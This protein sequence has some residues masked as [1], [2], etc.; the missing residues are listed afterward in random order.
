[1]RRL[2][3]PI[4]R[5]I[6]VSIWLLLAASADVVIFPVSAGTV[7]SIRSLD[8]PD[9]KDVTAV[10][11]RISML[12]Q[13][14]DPRR[15][16]LPPDVDQAY[17]RFEKRIAERRDIDRILDVLTAEKDYWQVHWH[18]APNYSNLIEIFDSIRG[19]TYFRFDPGDC[20]DGGDFLVLPQ[21][22]ATEML[23]KGFAPKNC[24]DLMAALSIP[25]RFLR[26]R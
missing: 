2:V 24:R 23:I 6:L 3:A 1:M 20:R 4:R 15:D 7:L 11:V 25:D 16:G 17:D 5:R 14:I 8:L 9:A 19:V 12:R 13:N 26:A 10:R 21:G 18:T 22:R